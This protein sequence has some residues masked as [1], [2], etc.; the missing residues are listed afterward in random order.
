[1]RK[2]KN[3]TEVLKAARWMLDNIGWVQNHYRQ[4]DSTGKAI[5]FC[6][7]GAL[8]T[9]KTKKY[10]ATNSAFKRLRAVVDHGLIV[11]FNDAPGRT[12]QEVLNAFDQAIKGPNKKD[13]K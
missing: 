6:A 3:G 7:V 1:M 11:E 13:K 4:D 10:G 2:A 5:G 8:E 12:K 9:V